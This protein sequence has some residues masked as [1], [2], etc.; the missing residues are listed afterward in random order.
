[1]SILLT[2]MISTVISKWTIENDYELRNKKM[3]NKKKVSK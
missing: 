2:W 3:N 1:M